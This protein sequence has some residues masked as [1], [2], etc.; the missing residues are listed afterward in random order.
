[1]R[2]I[3]IILLLLSSVLLVAAEESKLIDSKWDELI[4]PSATYSSSKA[5]EIT[6]FPNLLVGE[7]IY[8][9]VSGSSYRARELQCFLNI[10]P[11]TIWI[12][13]KP[14]K[15]AELN[16][17]YKLMPFYH[18]VESSSYTNPQYT[19]AQEIEGINFFVDSVSTSKSDGRSYLPTYYCDVYLINSRTNER[20]IWR[21]ASDN[22][23]SDLTL[24]SATVAEKMIAPG[25]K[26][27]KKISS[28][29]SDKASDFQEFIVK[30]AVYECHIS[31][32]GG[33]GKL[34]IAML[35]SDE[36]QNTSFVYSKNMSYSSPRVI[37]RDDYLSLVESD[38]VYEIDS[39]LPSEDEDYIFPFN[40]SFIL[41]RTNAGY[42]YQTI[43]KSTNSYSYYSSSDRDFIGSNKIIQIADKQRIHGKD[44]YIGLYANKCFYIST[45]DVELPYE[46]QMKLDSLLACSTDIRNNFFIS[47]K[48]LEHESYILNIREAIKELESFNKYGLSIISWGVYD[49]SEYT[50]GT[51]F[52]IKFYNPTNKTIK[53]IT[54]NLVG[55]NAVDDAVSS[56]GKYTLSPKCVGPIEPEDAG[57]YD[58]EYLW[59]TD[60][61]EYAKIKSIVVQYTNGTT[62]TISNISNIEW[63]DKLYETYF[64]SELDKLQKME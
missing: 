7:T 15:N 1:M 17:H 36:G 19:P 3:F 27:Y 56:R 13:K 54:I 35:S 20:L 48:I 40:F 18:G 21:Y 5:I 28:S 30:S 34:N 51:G 58:F 8:F 23:S 6:K 29:Y 62:K 12:K 50:D 60:L 31:S 14:K 52:R 63:S 33:Y 11:D 41:G 2:R 57:S 26:I 4:S 43:A 46:E 47:S 49:Q 61:V 10:M 16:K 45:S 59:F 9:K 25:T 44:Y 53:Y 55:Y 39:S 38:R 22:S 24:Y 32:V 37:N 64:S 42:V